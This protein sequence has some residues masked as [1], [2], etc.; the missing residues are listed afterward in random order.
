MDIQSG[1]KG[2]YFL[3]K[4]GEKFGEVVWWAGYDRPTITYS[5]PPGLKPAEEEL[6]L[7]MPNPW[8]E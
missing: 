7:S 4:D 6:I 3:F 1:P 8:N 2:T 5:T